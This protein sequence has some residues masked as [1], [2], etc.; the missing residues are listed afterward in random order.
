MNSIDEIKIILTE[1][2]PLYDKFN[3]KYSKSYLQGSL[4]YVGDDLL[5]WWR[6]CNNIRYYE[7]NVNKIMIIIEILTNLKE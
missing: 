6:K 7:E 4:W 3:S 2:Q 1:I 5:E